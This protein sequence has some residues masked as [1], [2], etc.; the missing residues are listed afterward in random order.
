MRCSVHQ[1]PP[2]LLPAHYA[3]IPAVLSRLP[4]LCPPLQPQLVLADQTATIDVTPLTVLQNQPLR[5]TTKSVPA[6]AIT[7]NAR[8]E[9]VHT[10]HAPAV[11]TLT[12]AFPLELAL[13]VSVMRRGA[14]RPV[15]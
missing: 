10:C 8:V 14:L 6:A 4:L 12:V 2:Q 3:S 13:V 11:N 9:S 7:A 5:G 1:V 15:A